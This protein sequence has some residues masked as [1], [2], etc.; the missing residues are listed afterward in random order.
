MNKTFSTYR[1]NMALLVSCCC[2]AAVH[3]VCAAGPSAVC[4][5]DGTYLATADEPGRIQYRLASDFTVQGTFYLCHPRA[6]CFSENGKL[7]AAAGARNG[8]PAKI[9][10]WRLGDHQQLCDITTSNE[11]HVLALSRDGRL[12]AGISSDGLLA[13]WCVSN[14][15]PDWSRICLGAVESMRFSPDSKQLLIRLGD[16]SERQYDAGTARSLALHGKE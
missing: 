1:R 2:V 11:V 8:S 5:P 9:K 13:V 12:I 14:G 7:L 4:S 16:G 15:Q 3:G 10:V 6:I